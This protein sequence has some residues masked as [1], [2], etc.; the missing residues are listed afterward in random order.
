MSQVAINANKL[1][2][3]NRV[4]VLTAAIFAVFVMM[5]SPL[6]ASETHAAG[7]GEGAGAAAHGESHGLPAYAPTLTEGGF[8]NNS[9]IVTWIVAALVIFGVQRAMRNRKEV[10]SGGQNFVEFLVD[11]LHG[12]LSQIMGRDLARQTFWFFASLFLFI[13]AT[14]WAGLFPGVGTIGWSSVENAASPRVFSHHL[15]T[16]LFRGGNADLNMTSAMAV[17]FFFWWVVWALKA[18]G[19]VGFF[20]HIF[21]PKGESKGAMKVAMIVIFGI[22]GVL[23]VISIMF[24]PVSLSFRLYGNVFAG[25]TMLESM[26]ALVPSLGWLIPV[27]FYFMEL[28]VGLVQALVF[29]LLTS[30]FTLLICEHHEEHGEGHDDHGHGE[31]DA[32]KAH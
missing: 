30:V 21:A 4:A 23:E 17:T 8:I 6:A 10:P 26:Q 7:A 28:L 2:L 32:S 20:K 1:N 25:E 12:F 9:M 31:K 24:R 19:P 16:P 14:N 3:V 13:L 15:E 27:P 5:I 29:M 22:V 18:N 11:G